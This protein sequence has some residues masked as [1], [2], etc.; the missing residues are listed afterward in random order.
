MEIVQANHYRS[1]VYAIGIPL[2]KLSC[3]HM[4]EMEIYGYYNVWFLRVY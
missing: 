4:N 1:I 2:S 3:P